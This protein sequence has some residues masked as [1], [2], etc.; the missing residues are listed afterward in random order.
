M[1]STSPGAGVQ[2]LSEPAGPEAQMPVDLGGVGSRGRPGPGRPGARPNHRTRQ[3]TG[4]GRRGE[5]ECV[6]G[7]GWEGPDCVGRL[8]EAHT[9]GGGEEASPATEGMRAGWVFGLA[10]ADFK[11][12]TPNTDQTAVK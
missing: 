2:S 7:E 4:T 3:N 1:R 10:P 9:G 11:E 12:E 8:L 5:A 6:V